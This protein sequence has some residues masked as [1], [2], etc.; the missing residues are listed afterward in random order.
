MF[1]INSYKKAN[2]HLKAD[3]LLN[4]HKT[5][6][7]P[8]MVFNKIKIPLDELNDIYLMLLEASENIAEEDLK[9]IFSYLI[10]SNELLPDYQMCKELSE[11]M[12]NESPLFY[13]FGKVIIGD[14]KLPMDNL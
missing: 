12:S 5:E 3:E 8:N 6:I 14:E 1:A 13:D 7:S 2:K 9:E 11:N 10:A 4:F